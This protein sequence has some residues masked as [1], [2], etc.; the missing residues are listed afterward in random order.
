MSSQTAVMVGRYISPASSVECVTSARRSDR[1]DSAGTQLP[2]PVRA[3]SLS[4][5]EVSQCSS[6]PEACGV[7]DGTRRHPDEKHVDVQSAASLS[8]SQSDVSY[9]D[10]DDDNDV[11]VISSSSTPDDGDD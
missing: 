9:V 4:V 2:D 1:T 11:I 5:P 10:D 3:R 6:V 8:E 7:V